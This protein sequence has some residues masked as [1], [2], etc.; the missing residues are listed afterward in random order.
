MT[1]NPTQADRDAAAKFYRKHLHREGE[2]LVADHMQAGKIDESPLVQAFAS[3]RIQSE[4]STSPDV[5]EAVK[6]IVAARDHAIRSSKTDRGNIAIHPSAWMALCDAIAALASTEQPTQSDA[7]AQI[8][9]DL[10][11]R[12]G[13]A[14][15][16]AIGKAMDILKAL[17]DG[18]PYVD[19][20]APDTHEGESE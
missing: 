20:D 14:E 4:Q 10:V 6:R 5:V 8:D 15:T 11:A 1:N 2:V 7:I 13:A 16:L 9:D 18:T 19:L 3:H 12:L 17:K